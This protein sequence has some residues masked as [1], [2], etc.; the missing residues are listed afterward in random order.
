MDVS[1]QLELKE[2][3]RLRRAASGSVCEEEL[4][5]L[6]NASQAIQHWR[7]ICEYHYIQLLDIVKSSHLT[8]DRLAE[9]TRAGDPVPLRFVYEAH[10]VGFLQSLH[11]L[12]DS[13]PYLLNL[14]IPKYEDP[15]DRA[16]GWNKRFIA[17]YGQESFALELSELWLHDD[18][19]SLKGYVNTI[20][21]KRLVRVANTFQDL[22]LESVLVRY[23]Y[24]SESGEVTESERHMPRIN[25]LRFF[26]SCHDVLVLK[27]FKLCNLVQRAQRELVSSATNAR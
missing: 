7:L 26:E 4:E 11:A 15:E 2:F 23:H 9:Y 22:E 10:V 25:V 18:F 3:V 13:F 20:K 24:R 27:L 1:T 8:L 21:H 5:K 16:I 12:L 17:L 14:C 6:D 19:Q